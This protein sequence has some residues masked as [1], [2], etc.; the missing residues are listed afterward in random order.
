MATT[1]NRLSLEDL[2]AMEDAVQKAAFDYSVASVKR[3]SALRRLTEIAKIPL[4]DRTVEQH[5]EVTET[6]IAVIAYERAM[7]DAERTAQDIEARVVIG[8][9][10]RMT[11]ARRSA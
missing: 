5:Q 9:E 3:A 8:Q 10:A 7:S 4:D 2:A 11:T 1:R 6:K